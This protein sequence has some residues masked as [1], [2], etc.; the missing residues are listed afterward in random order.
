[1][2]L[3]K[4]LHSLTRTRLHSERHKACVCVIC[5]C[6]IIGTEKMNWLSEEDLLRKKEYLSVKYLERC[7]E[8][9][10][11][12]SLRDQYRVLDNEKL[13]GLI[14]SP[15]ATVRD[16]MHMTCITCHRNILSD[17]D[18]PPK[19]GLTNGWVIGQLPQ[20]VINKEIDDILAAALAKI[21]IFSNVY[22][23]SAG[24]HKSIK[25]HHVFF[26]NNPQHVGASFE[27]MLKF[28]LAHEIY[29]MICG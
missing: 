15:R 26:A 28:G 20:Y 23:F 9:T 4:C 17:A 29:I 10:I 25:G 3:K 6:F 22:S 8:K 2:F 12:K 24:A 18:K 5:D 13:D 11:P 14:L 21:R 19:F 27:Y 16:G 7:V 1:M